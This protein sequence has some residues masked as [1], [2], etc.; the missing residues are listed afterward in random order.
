MLKEYYSSY[1]D[2]N[3]K[4]LEENMQLREDNEWLRKRNLELIHQITLMEELQTPQEFLK[5]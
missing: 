3:A 2:M 5:E 1:M 4:L